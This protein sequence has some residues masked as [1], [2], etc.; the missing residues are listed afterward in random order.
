MMD[1]SMTGIKAGDAIACLH[2]IGAENRIILAPAFDV[3]GQRR[4][5][6]NRKHLQIIGIAKG[7]SELVHLTL[8]AHFFIYLSCQL[9]S[10]FF[11]TLLCL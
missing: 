5:F 7:T 4:R 6:L 11:Y 8:P 10:L 1:S 3:Y 2:I 9:T